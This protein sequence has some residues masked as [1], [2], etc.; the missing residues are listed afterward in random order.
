MLLIKKIFSRIHPN[1][2][3]NSK[4]FLSDFSSV[5]KQKGTKIDESNFTYIL[6]L[7]DEFFDEYDTELFNCDIKAILQENYKIL[8]DNIY[9]AILLTVNDLI[10]YGSLKIYDDF[11]NAYNQ[12]IKNKKYSYFLHEKIWID[13][14]KLINLIYV[15]INEFNNIF[16]EKKFSY[17]FIQILSVL[18]KTVHNLKIMS[19]EEKIKEV[20]YWEEKE[21][22]LHADT[23][24]CITINYFYSGDTF[25]NERF[26]NIYNESISD[27]RLFAF[28]INKGNDILDKYFDY[29]KG[30][31]LK[32]W[33][34]LY[35]EISSLKYSKVPDDMNTIGKYLC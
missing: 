14:N 7:C 18:E 26:I 28:C 16:S 11:K 22:N 20:Y 8:F 6:N 4:D 27:M 21:V 10:I 1:I 3:F 29:N 12:I 17:A 30:K 23:H 33:Y 2:D 5:L 25:D 24:L 34:N 13:Y 15:Y 32:H 19:K 35:K 9:L 31:E